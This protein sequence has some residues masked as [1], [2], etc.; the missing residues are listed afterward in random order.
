MRRAPGSTTKETSG[1]IAVD[2]E[3]T[4]FSP[5]R[6]DRIIE[7]AA[8]AFNG[9]GITKEFQSLINAGKRI[10]FHARQVHG[11]TDEML[12]DAP[13]PDDVFAR[14]QSF[15]K[16]SVLVAH[17][18]AFDV[19]F[20]RHEFGRLGMGFDRRYHC[21]LEMCR[22]R[23]PNLPNHR[24]ETVCRHL[25]GKEMEGVRLHRALDDARMVARVW[26]EMGKR[27]ED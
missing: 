11:I 23:F 18:A 16:D 10:P 14:F 3:T 6:G 20:L 12:M 13:G 9:D 27:E 2:V 8:V 21:T 4:G 7:I 15:M 26:M 5:L 25:F 24:L 1:F 19:G 17:N 22:M